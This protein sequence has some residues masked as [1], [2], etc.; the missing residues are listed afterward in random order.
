MFEKFRLAAVLSLSTYFSINPLPQTTSEPR[1]RRKTPCTL[2][3]EW[4]RGR[5]EVSTSTV[6]RVWIPNKVQLRLVKLCEGKGKMDLTH[7][8][9]KITSQACQ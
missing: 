7:Q 9:W 3:D 4:A 1:A 8:T 5:R 6:L 2:Q